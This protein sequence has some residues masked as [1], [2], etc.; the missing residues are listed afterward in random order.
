M[1]S[2]ATCGVYRF[3]SCPLPALPVK[4]YCTVKTYLGVEEPGAICLE[5]AARFRDG[6]T[7]GGLGVGL[8]PIL[9]SRIKGKASVPHARQNNNVTIGPP[10]SLSLTALFRSTNRATRRNLCFLLDPRGRDRREPMFRQGTAKICATGNTVCDDAGNPAVY[11]RTTGHLKVY[12]QVLRGLHFGRFCCGVDLS[13]CE[14]WV[15]F[16]FGRRR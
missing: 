13:V 2:R 11:K 10:W 16:N 6:N 14:Q 5:P 4:S 8:A 9:T 7:S 1:Y 15:S 12:I 3:G